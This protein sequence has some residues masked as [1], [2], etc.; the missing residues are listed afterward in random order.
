MVCLEDGTVNGIGCGTG[1]E[2]EE[3]IGCATLWCAHL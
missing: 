3:G 1:R 2:I